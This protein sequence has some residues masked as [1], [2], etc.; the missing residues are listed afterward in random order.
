[1]NVKS[2]KKK[3]KSLKQLLGKHVRWIDLGNSGAKLQK[4]MLMCQRQLQAFSKFHF[5]DPVVKDELLSEE[6]VPT[7]PEMQ[8]SQLHSCCLCN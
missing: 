2:L 5:E 7:L 6:N 3:K 1:M 8:Y 4:K